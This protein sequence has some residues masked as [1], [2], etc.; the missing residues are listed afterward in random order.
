MFIENVENFFPKTLYTIRNS[1]LCKKY[2][3]YA[4][5]FVFKMQ[6]SAKLGT[7]FD[8][9]Y[10]FYYSSQLTVVITKLFLQEKHLACIFYASNKSYLSPKAVALAD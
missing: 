6:N 9:N 4:S 7:Y 5:L 8:L 3:A 10:F 2:N 1:S